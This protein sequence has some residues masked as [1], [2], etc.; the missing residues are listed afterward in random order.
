AGAQVLYDNGPYFNSVGTGANG[1]NESVL[2]TSTFA[3]GTIG[4]G[5]QQTAFNRIADDFMISDCA[6]R[7]DSVVFF[8][9]Q[10]NSTTTSTFTSVNFRIWN[11]IPDAVGSSVVYGDTTTNRLIRTAWSGAYRITETTT[12]NSARPIMRNVCTAGGVIL[13]GGTY[14]LDWSSAGSLASG[15]WAPARTPVLVAITGNGRQRTGSIWNNAVDGGTNT[16]AQGFP[17]IVYGT[18]LTATADAGLPGTFCDTG[19]LLLGGSP[20]GTGTGSLTY[21]WTPAAGLDNPAIANPTATTVATTSYVLTV[22]DSL[23][24]SASDTVVVGVSYTQTVVITQVVCGS[25]T[26]PSGNVYTASGIYVDT[27]PTAAG[28]DS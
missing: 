3:M 27:I 13:N 23:G 6:W 9:Y 16:P 24:C 19:I 22:T 14:W 26:S 4:F 21:N 8:G 12:G 20:A 10:T 1:A 7:I 15:P 25:Y 28:C 2:Y 18:A 17:F 11:G 5:N